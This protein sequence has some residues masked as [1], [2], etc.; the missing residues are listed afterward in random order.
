MIFNLNKSAQLSFV[1]FTLV[2]ALTISSCKTAKKIQA[3]VAKKD[4]V[5]VHITNQSADDSILVVKK[6][7][8]QVHKTENDFKTFSAKMKV[9][10]QDSKGKQPNIRP[11]LEY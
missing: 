9:E 3:S 4:T 5:S 2:A 1:F 6:A 10:Y 7:L 11:M 8:E